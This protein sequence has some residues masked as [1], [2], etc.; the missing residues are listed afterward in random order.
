MSPHRQALRNHWRQYYPEYEIPKGYHVHHILPRACGGTDD[1]RNLIALHPDD[2]VTIHRCRGDDVTLEKWIVSGG[3]RTPHTKE[4][5][6]K[7][8][9]KRAQQVITPEHCE[10]ISTQMRN[11]E[12]NPF[13]K[14]WKELVGDKAEE[15]SKDRSERMLKSNPN[16]IPVELD[17][18]HYRS[19]AHAMEETGLSRRVIKQ[20]Q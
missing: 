5:K 11:W 2:H 3:H 9:D 4:T 8:K 17:G 1:P 12:N 6:G 16:S 19:I 20:I 15:L 13:R 14:P 18:V 10:A 7:I